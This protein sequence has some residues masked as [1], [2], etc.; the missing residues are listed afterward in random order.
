MPVLPPIEESTMAR[1]VVGTWTTGVPRCQ[2]E[3]AKAA[4]SPT[5]P[6]PTATTVESR[7]SSASWKASST[8]SSPAIVLA[9]SPPL[10]RTVGTSFSSGRV[11]T[12]ESATARTFPIRNGGSFSSAPAPMRT[13]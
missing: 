10:T 12:L 8:R 5:V 9:P 6:P 1:K 4:R 13:G 7:P 2:I 11:G 3:A